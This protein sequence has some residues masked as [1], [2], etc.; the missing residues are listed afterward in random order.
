MQTEQT[1]TVAVKGGKGAQKYA[2]P[3]KKTEAKPIVVEE[4]AVEPVVVAEEEKKRAGEEDLDD[5]SDE[6][7]RFY[8]AFL[9]LPLWFWCLVG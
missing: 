3:A 7:V 2:P 9:H 4:S 1:K 5:D 8:L 6:N